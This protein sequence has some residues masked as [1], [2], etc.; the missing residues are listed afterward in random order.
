MM[1]SLDHP[2]GK[3]YGEPPVLSAWKEWE[4]DVVHG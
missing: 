4:A 1:A 2:L 3:N